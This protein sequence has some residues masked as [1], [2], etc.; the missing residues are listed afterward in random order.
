MIKN[1][2]I[3]TLE[4]HLLWML[5]QYCGITEEGGDCMTR[6]NADAEAVDYLNKKGLID[7]LEGE[8]PSTKRLK[9]RIS[10]KGKLRMELKEV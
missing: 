10:D 7:I 1:K 6:N 8:W 9:F 4:Y 5:F 2:I 3:Q